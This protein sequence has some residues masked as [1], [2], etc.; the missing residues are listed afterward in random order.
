MPYGYLVRMLVAVAS[1]ILAV[2]QL[3]AI[4]TLDVPLTIALY[5]FAVSIPAGVLHLISYDDAVARGIGIPTSI[6][7]I[8]AAIASHAVF[9]G[10]AAVFFHFATE[11]GTVFVAASG[12]ASHPGDLPPTRSKRCHSRSASRRFARVAAPT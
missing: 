1:A 7:S 8:S 5:S 9:V 3:I 12:V 6:V 2:I 11:L 10:F 4:S